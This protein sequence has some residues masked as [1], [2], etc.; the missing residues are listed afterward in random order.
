MTLH[1]DHHPTPNGSAVSPGRSNSGGS[2]GLG[3]SGAT[4]KRPEPPSPESPQSSKKAR[5]D[6]SPKSAT[7]SAVD[8][9]TVIEVLNTPR[10]TSPVPRLDNATV[11]TRE[12]EPSKS[13]ASGS[14]ER[15]DTRDAAVE[16][17]AAAVLPESLV[18]KP[19]DTGASPSALQSIV[20]PAV[21]PPSVHELVGTTESGADSGDL[22]IEPAQSE[23]VAAATS[24]AAVATDL[25]G[26]ESADKA[27]GDAD[28]VMAMAETGLVTEQTIA[29]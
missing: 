27:D 12:A 22:R 29:A 14:Q 8:K 15:E 6:A 17:D 19:D 9:R 26:E 21:T 11:E 20:Q 18:A 23:V 4:N 24:E 3:I 10:I 1:G 16:I 5:A 25:S 13:L 7:R 28:V 2:L